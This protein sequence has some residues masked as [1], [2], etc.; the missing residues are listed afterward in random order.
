MSEGIVVCPRE[1]YVDTSPVK[2][3]GRQKKLLA[4]VLQIAM[5]T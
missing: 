2:N 3:Q 5:S 1:V 4:N